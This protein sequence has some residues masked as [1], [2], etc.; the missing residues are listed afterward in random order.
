MTMEEPIAYF[1]LQNIRAV[2]A[3]KDQENMIFHESVMCEYNIIPENLAV[4]L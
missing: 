4:E 3:L 1:L 2:I